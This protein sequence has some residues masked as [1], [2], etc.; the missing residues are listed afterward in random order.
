MKTNPLGALC[1]LAVYQN[2]L[3]FFYDFEIVHDC[4]SQ[5][6]FCGKQR[7]IQLWLVNGTEDVC[8]AFSQS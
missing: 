3:G 1:L 6:H 4:V 5:V 2:A 7:L 8:A